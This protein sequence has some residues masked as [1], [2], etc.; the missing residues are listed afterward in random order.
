[1]QEALLQDQNSHLQFQANERVKTLEVVMQETETAF[2]FFC[3]LCNRQDVFG[4]AA[5]NA[6]EQVFGSETTSG[7]PADCQH[8]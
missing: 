6:T 5:T 1:M 3:P 8:G 7:L 4:A 2:T